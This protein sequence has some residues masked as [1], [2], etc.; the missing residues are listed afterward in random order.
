MTQAADYS[1]GAGV[2]L[3]PDYEGSGDYEAVP[4]PYGQ[5]LFD[6][7]MY[8]QLQGLKL[9]A[10]LLPSNTWRLG[11]VYNYRSSRSVVDNSQVDDM[12]NVSDAN[13]L[14]AFGGVKIENWFAELEFLADTGNAYDG[15]YATL[16]GGY[17]WTFSDTWAFTFGAHGTYAN[18]DYMSTYFG[19]DA[20]DSARSGLSQY[21]ADSG[22]KDIGL[23][24][25]ANWSITQNWSLRGVAEYSLL[26]GDANDD[27]PVTDEGSEHQFFGGVL[28]VFN[29]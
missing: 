24:L 28:V 16:S 22:I 7:G 29:F 11:P 8:V 20:G 9:K 13:E 2:G 15:W 4:I 1:V 18:E 12:K 14:G 17:N 21:N 6:N 23:D 19:V 27:S 5:I 3:A 26:V 10:N 25:G